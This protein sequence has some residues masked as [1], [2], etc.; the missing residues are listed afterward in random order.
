MK[1][2]NIVMKRIFTFS[3]IL[4]L[5]LF[6]CRKEKNDVL[7]QFKNSSK[8]QVYSIIF[9]YD[10]LHFSFGYFGDE[11]GVAIISKPKNSKFCEILNNQ[12]QE[13]I[14][15]YIPQN[16]FLGIDSVLVVSMKGSDGAGPST[17]VDTIMVI[18][19]VVKDDFH[20]KLIGRWNWI[21]NC[22]GYTGGCWYA[23]ENNKSLIEFTYD[24]HY[25]QSYNDSVIHDLIYHFIE[26]F[27]VGETITYK[28]G[29]SDKFD[30]Y[31][32]FTKDTLNIQQGDA[33][34]EYEKIIYFF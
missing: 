9:S 13:R 18:I 14:L 27:K 15:N 28:I 2:R 34:A 12:L 25:I 21:R 31:L 24:M 8:D 32:W 1:F 20:K 10:T 17:N 16:N 7:N 6:S 19:K 33:V 11:E 23:D 29:F 22:G 26:S 5:I 4:I 3:V 30:T